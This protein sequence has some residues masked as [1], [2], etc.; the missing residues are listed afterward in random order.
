MNKES[1]NCWNIV[2][3]SFGIRIKIVS[4]F[5]KL[6]IISNFNIKKPLK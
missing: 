1:L 5:D 3:F 6:F 2:S 4:K